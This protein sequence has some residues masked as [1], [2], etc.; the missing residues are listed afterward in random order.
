MQRERLTP[1]RIRR[2]TCPEG[3]KQA[4]LWDT[5]APRLAVRATAGAKAF[6]FESKLNRRTIR[7]TIG[8]VRAWALEDARTEARRLQTEI[9]QGTDPRE[10]KAER[11]AASEARREE[12]RRTEASALE[13]WNAYLQAR[14]ARWSP[15]TLLDHQRLSDPGGKPKTR[16]RKKGEGDTTQ[17]GI[18][19]PLLAHPLKKID[20]TAVRAFLKN[21]AARRPT[22][23]KNAFTRL[24]AF[25]NWCAERPEYQGQIH[26]DAC[27]SRAARDELPKRA[28]KDDCLQ[29]EQ[30]RPWFA[31]VRALPAVPAAYLQ[32][33]LLTGARREELASLRWEDV[34]FQWNSL[35]IRDKVEGERTIPLTPFVAGLLRDLKRRNDTPPPQ[36]RILH[37]QRIQNDLSTWQPSPWVFSS[38]TA[39]SGR[40][41]EPRAAHNRAL[42][43][44]GLP[45]LTL[46]GLRRSFGTLAEWVECPAGVSAQIMGHKP[47]A[48]AE[49]HYRRRPLD[50]LRVWHTKIEGWILEQAGIEQPRQ[51]EAAPAVRGVA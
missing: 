3:T 21:E 27:T 4:F 35:R 12:L 11:I 24:R 46:H 10:E 47:S 7:V 1:E 2:F 41:Q 50:L 32:S 23:A 38:K 45:P 26:P 48:L 49:K 43:A 39:A 30:L 15:R 44:A 51:Q 8:D 20:G 33:L 31:A 5:E 37:S 13:A 18:L 40:L 14:C 42:T 17:P 16:G 36:W 25:L 22:Q 29:R 6:I 19:L 28:P 9:D 34:D